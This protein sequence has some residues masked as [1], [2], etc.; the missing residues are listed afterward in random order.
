MMPL[1]TA[2][3][4]SD[5]AHEGLGRAPLSIGVR[6][7]AGCPGRGLLP[8]WHDAIEVVRVLEGSM[9]FCVDE[10]DVALS[11][12]QC[13]LIGSRQVHSCAAGSDGPC[14][15]VC[16]L[17]GLELFSGSP[18]VRDELIAPIVEREGTGCIV[19]DDGQAARV[20][21]MLQLDG[22]GPAGKL[23]M[24]GLLH[25]ILAGAW[26][27]LRDAEA[28]RPLMDRADAAA[29]KAMVSYIC[30]R[31]PEKISLADIAAAGHVCRSRCCSIFKRWLKQSPI[32]FLNAYRLTVSLALLRDT[33][34]RIADIA[35]ACGF[36]HQSYYGKM[37]V[38]RYGCTPSEHRARLRAGRAA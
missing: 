6:D 3:D 37:F 28:H 13:L 38:R 8:H 24:L 1:D 11:A 25:T 19:L 2:R 15:Y 36:V 23:E 4:A 30:R 5:M 21:R 12:G 35:A 34:D 14:R 29:Q 18:W 20:D 27:S 9:S 26:A 31:Y 33:D 10:E 32:E 22:Q 7:L 16:I 17:A